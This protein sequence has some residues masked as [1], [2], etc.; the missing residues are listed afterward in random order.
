M[1]A[2]CVCNAKIAIQEACQAV[3]MKRD[4]LHPPLFKIKFRD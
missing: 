1:S 3:Q 4:D 2:G